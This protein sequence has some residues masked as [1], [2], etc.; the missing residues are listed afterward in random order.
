MLHRPILSCRVGKWAYALIEYDLVYEF[1]KAIKGQIVADFIVEHRVEDKH[2]LDVG[3]ISLVPWELYFDGSSCGVGQGLGVII[4]SPNGAVFETSSRLEHYCTNNQAKYE[5]LLFGLQMLQS[6]EVKC[7]KAF[8]DSL[9]VVQQIDRICQCL[10][11]LLNVY[12]DKCLEVI[13]NF[14][15]FTVHHLPRHVNS[16]ANVLA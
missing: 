4:I 6:M 7:V 3:Y 5:A 15:E 11:G 9:L 14:D 2:D 10:S 13:S 1:L 12:L 8:G 16:R